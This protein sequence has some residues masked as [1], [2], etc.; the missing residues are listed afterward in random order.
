MG[1]PALV[2]KN[3]CRPNVDPSPLTSTF[4]EDTELLVKGHTGFQRAVVGFHNPGQIVGVDLVKPGGKVLQIG[5]TQ[6]L[7]H[8]RAGQ[9]DPSQEGVGRIHGDPV[10]SIAPGALH[11]RAHMALTLP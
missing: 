3:R 7:F 6:Q 1:Q 11:Q 5:Y 2:V 4:I 10:D 8:G 9:N